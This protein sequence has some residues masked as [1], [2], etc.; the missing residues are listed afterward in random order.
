[1]ALPNT[2]HQPVRG[3]TGCSSARRVAVIRPLRS[4]S[5][6][7][8]RL[9]T[10]CSGDRD[11]AGQNLDLAVPAR[12]RDTAAASSGRRSGGDRAVGGSTRRRGRGRGTAAR[13]PPSAPGSRGGCSARVKAVNCSASS[14]RSHAAVRAVTPA[15]GS[16]D[17]S[18]KT[19]LTVS[20]TV[21][22]STGPTARQ[23]R[24]A[25]RVSGES[26][27]PMTGTVAT[28]AMSAGQREREPREKAA[29]RRGHVGWDC[30]LHAG[31][32]ERDDRRRETA[33]LCRTASATSCAAR[34]SLL[35]NAQSR[36][37]SC[38]RREHLTTRWRRSG[39]HSSR[40]NR[41]P[42]QQPQHDNRQP[43][44]GRP[45]DRPPPAPYVFSDTEERPCRV[46]SLS[47]RRRS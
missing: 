22:P 28:A 15:H 38:R 6:A 43:F 37:P 10:V 42:P 35:D 1:M 34:P 13:R 27:K 24:G 39:D 8:R 26:R 16:G 11:G 5:Q 19:T 7:R 33:N 31:S 4:S 36:F 45:R 40:P 9:S 47:W 21:N 12:G 41:T 44:V 30:R 25:S 46:R 18:S 14:R 20:P 29:A 23:T 17:A 3:G 2:Y 32:A